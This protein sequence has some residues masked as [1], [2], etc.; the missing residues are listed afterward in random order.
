ME[1][2]DRKSL[3]LFSIRI[4]TTLTGLTPR[5]IRY[6]E[7]KEL[8]T[9]SR[10][11]G[12][13]RLFSYNDVDR[14]MEIKALKDKGLNIAG[15]KEV[16]EMKNEGIRKRAGETV[17]RAD[18]S[19]EELHDLLRKELMQ[20]GYVHHTSINRGDLSRFYH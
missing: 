14:L 5:Q 17:H 7:E 15:I 19:E 6:Y 13:Q 2:M 3:P 4:V 18:L 1:A 8:I 9:P 12:K 20:A 16:L 10:S 11:K